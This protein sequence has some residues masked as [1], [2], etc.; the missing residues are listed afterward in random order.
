MKYRNLLLSIAFFLST[1]FV[2]KA[3]TCSSIDTS[4]KL[5]PVCLHFQS[6]CC[7][8]PDEKALQD[9]IADFKKRK[10]VKQI[11]ALRVGPMGRE[12]EYDLY[13]E[14]GKMKKCTFKKFQEELQ[15]VALKMK[16]P[17]MVVYESNV[18]LREPASHDIKNNYEI[19]F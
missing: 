11:K 8:V 12:G 2:S 7:G 13:F 9:W 3:N 17:G 19:I 15:K 18:T 5:Y 1:T 16:E 4:I 10:H 14:R 6:I